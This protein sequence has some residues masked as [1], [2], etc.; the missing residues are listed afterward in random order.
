VGGGGG[1]EPIYL[2]RNPFFPVST[3]RTGRRV[4]A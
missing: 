2:D 3:E 1:V 4:K